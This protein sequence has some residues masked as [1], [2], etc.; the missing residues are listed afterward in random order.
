M[1]LW[2]REFNAS[3]RGRLQFTG[4]DMQYLSV[5]MDNVWAF[6][7]RADPAYLG[8]VN[9]AYAAAQQVNTSYLNGG[10]VDRSTVI[11]AAD[12]ARAVWQYLQ[13]H[14]SE[15]AGVF[16]VEQ[17]DWAIQNGR[18]VEQATYNATRELDYRDRCMAE[19]FE[20]ILQHN[21]PGTRAVIWAH[22][23]HI[24]RTAYGP[25]A[26]GWY[27]AG[28]HDNDYLPVMQLFGEGGYNAISQEGLGVNQAVPAYPG[29]L[30]YVLHSTGMSSFLLDMRKVAADDPNAAWMLGDMEFRD[31]GAV[32][33][34]DFSQTGTLLWDWDVIVYFDR[35]TPSVLLPF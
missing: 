35:V 7:Q 28:L 22:N 23:G 24:S 18:I 30:E 25:A 11:A 21:P 10:S 26:M 32:A 9:G 5:A 3:G 13:Q 14:R 29:T 33:S 4:F 17:I 1:I 8:V 34:V 27:V 15:Y 16:S 2:M 19:N 31:I 20:W 6:V 12:A